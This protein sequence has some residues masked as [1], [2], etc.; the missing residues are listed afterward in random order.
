[1]GE[2]DLS[3]VPDVDLQLT[4]AVASGD[5]VIVDLH[6]ATFADSVILGAI[7]KANAQA[8]RRG[9]AV[10]MPPP[11][12]VARLFDLVDARSILATFPTMGV[13]I[14][15]CHLVSRRASEEGTS[16]GA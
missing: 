16:S 6:V 1:M 12:E 3:T 15:W 5:P 2:H 13:A 11:G 4:L 14:D 10:V 8:G 9:L 7:L